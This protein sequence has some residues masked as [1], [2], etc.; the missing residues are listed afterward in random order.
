MT[1]HTVADALD[2]GRLD[3]AELDTSLLQEWGEALVPG[4][5]RVALVIALALIAYRIVLFMT[6]GLEREIQEKDPVVKRL[7]EQ[8]GR[9]IASLLN[10]VARITIVALAALTILGTLLDINIGPLLAGVGVFGLAVSF[11]AQSLVKDIINGVLVLI[12]GQ[13]GIGDVIRVD[14]TAGMVE[15]ITLRITVLRDMHGVVHVIPNGEINKLSNLT[16][17]WSRAVLDLRVAYTEDVDRVLEVL[18]DLGAE[19]NDDL[20]WGPSLTEPPSV[21][22]VQDFLESAMIIRM[23]ATTLPLKQWNVARELRRRIKNRFDAEGIRIPYPHLTFY[24]G[25]GQLP[26]ATDAQ[27]DA[28]QI[29]D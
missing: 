6:Q 8:R 27:R 21:L 16:K 23:T 3:L 17:V 28:R 12:E 24:W 19:L 7:R 29:V 22:G 26:P 4:L 14:G 10:N 5:L 2:Q 9:T 11:G 25:D 18:R 20:E 15:R 1:L 13:Y